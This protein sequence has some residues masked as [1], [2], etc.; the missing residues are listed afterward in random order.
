MLGRQLHRLA[1]SMR[2][3]NPVLWIAFPTGLVAVSAGLQ[4][5]TIYYCADDY[6]A[7]AGVDHEPVFEMEKQL[8]KEADLVF[9]TS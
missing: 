1:R 5:K 3:E 9:A 7:L 8:V 4:D 6:G 2:L